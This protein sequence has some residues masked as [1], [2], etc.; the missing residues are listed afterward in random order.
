MGGG[1]GRVRELLGAEG[2]RVRVA[3]APRREPERGVDELQEQVVLR[4]AL[5]AV[6]LRPREVGPVEGEVDLYGVCDAGGAA[7]LA[8][9]GHA[10]VGR[11]VCARGR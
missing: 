10:R 3:V 9:S 4:P 7:G 11:G 5:R 8:G 1:E 2:R 6:A